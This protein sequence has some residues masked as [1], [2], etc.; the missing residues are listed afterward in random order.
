MLCKM[1][2]ELRMSCL[3]AHASSGV[4]VINLDAC[5]EQSGHG[6]VVHIF[7]IN[8]Y[9]S[10]WRRGNSVSCTFSTNVC[11]NVHVGGPHTCLGGIIR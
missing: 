1:N 9:R 3:V 10:R 7:Q 11:R 8:L 4:F 6:N 2:S 5:W